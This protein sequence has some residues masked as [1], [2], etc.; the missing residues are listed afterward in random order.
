[1]STAAKVLLILAGLGGVAVLLCCGGGILMMY[2][3]KSYIKDAVTEDPAKIAAR[4]EKM[5]SLDIP[6]GFRPQMSMDMTIP[7]SHRS[8]MTW[9]AYEEEKTNSTITLVTIGQAFPQ[10]NRDQML[11]EVQ[12]SLRQQGVGARQDTS[13]WTT[14]QKTFTVR[15]KE[16][17]FAY[18]CN[19]QDDQ[20]P[21]RYEVLGWVPGKDGPVMINISADAK[22]LDEKAIDRLIE[23]IR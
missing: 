3:G 14:Q 17:T 8:M 12:Q 11:R 6:Q 5:L 10:Q 9:V 22:T 15:G 23:S 18:R 19:A 13:G 16:V 2:W 20:E 1:M 4:A 21:T 7:F